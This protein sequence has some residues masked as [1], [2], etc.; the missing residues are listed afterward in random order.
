MNWSRLLALFII[1]NLLTVLLL[2]FCG[3]LN[4][5][6]IS[7]VTSTKFYAYF[8]FDY[9]EPVWVGKI[10]TLNLD[11]RLT[12][13]SQV[14]DSRADPHNYSKTVVSKFEPCFIVSFISLKSKISDLCTN[15]LGNRCDIIAGINMMS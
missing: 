4:L 9:P 1:I 6:K 15:R 14:I 12:V 10:P 2:N 13:K 11:N 5:G 8:E 7:E 3:L